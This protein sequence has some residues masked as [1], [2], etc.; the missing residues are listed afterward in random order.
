MFEFNADDLFAEVVTEPVRIAPSLE[1]CVRFLSSL[2][3]DYATVQNGAGWNK[4]DRERGHKL[5]MIDHENWSDWDRQWAWKSTRKYVNTQLIPNG[6]NADLIPEPPAPKIPEP[7]K[8]IDVMSEGMYSGDFCIKVKHLPTVEFNN[9]RSNVY[10][11]PGRHYDPNSKSWIVSPDRVSAAAL[12]K[13]A[14]DQGF[15]VTSE[16]TD[17]IFELCDRAD[18]YAR[19]SRAVKPSEVFETPDSRLWEAQQA[20]VEYILMATQKAVMTGGQNGHGCYVVDEMGTGKTATALMAAYEAARRRGEELRV[21]WICPANTKYNAQREAYHW[22]GKCRDPY[23]D[24]PHLDTPHI[25]DLKVTVCE[26]RG[27]QSIAGHVVIVNYDLL[28]TDEDGELNPLS[29][30]ISMGGWNGIV[31]DESHYAKNPIAARTQAVME[32]Y[33]AEIPFKLAM[34]GSP[35]L[36]RTEE[37]VPMLEALGLLK[38]FGNAN[39]FKGMYAGRDGNRKELNMK[40]REIPGWL[41]R[42]KRDHVFTPDGMLIPLDRVPAS[43]MPAELRD[44]E[45][46]HEAR[47]WLERCGYEWVEGAMQQL[48]NKSREVNLMEMPPKWLTEYTRV[49]TQFREWL[50][51]YYSSIDTENG[52]D[53]WMSSM[54]N[55]ILV[56]IG[57]LRQIC[58]LGKVDP[59]ASWIE[60]VLVSDEKLVVFVAHRETQAR[61]VKKLARWNPL[62]IYGGQSA[63]ERDKVVQTFQHDPNSRLIIAQLQAGGEGINLTAACHVAILEQAWNPGKLDQA[64]DRIDRGGQKR[65][66]TMHFLF[67]AKTI[68][69]RMSEIVDTKRIETTAAIHGGEA[70]QNS[71]IGQMLEAV[72]DT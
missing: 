65:D 71:M 34:S 36:N 52:R 39:A 28:G 27:V 18:A 7:V 53:R 24:K 31:A 46:K 16:A 66:V 1:D 13:F 3:T 57:K 41:G 44:A 45:R 25:A 40:L 62:T 22:L 17:L 64:T 60:D 35:V 63:L 12:R 30:L 42:M 14:Q 59:A 32:L 19:M 5:A 68:D 21:L 47:R 50:L 8:V 11:V 37:M 67:S 6:L 49:L 69:Q 70:E 43:D 4:L 72:I 20:G 51:E 29:F 38:F 58:A 23:C 2:D 54:R 9:I 33:K 61:L 10:S 56:Q 48:P 26:G 55:E 15:E